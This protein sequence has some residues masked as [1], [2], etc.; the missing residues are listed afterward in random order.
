MRTDD[1][2]T[3]WRI[4]CQDLQNFTYMPTKF[5]IFEYS[6]IKYYQQTYFDEFMFK[7]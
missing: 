6:H 2:E 4:F 1:I 3:M 7:I 5:M